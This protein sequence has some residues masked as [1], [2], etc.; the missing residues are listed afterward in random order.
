MQPIFRHLALIMFFSLLLTTAVSAAI[1][2]KDSQVIFDVDYNQFSSDSQKQITSNGQLNILN[3]GTEVAN[4]TLSFSNLPA[5]YNAD[6]VT[7][8]S[9]AAGET[10]TIA[11]TIKVPHKKESGESTIGTIIVQDTATKATLASQ[12]LIQNTKSMLSLYEVEIVYTDKNGKIQTEQFTTENEK[13]NEFQLD[14]AVKPGTEVKMTF[15]IENLFDRDY[16]Q[17]YAEL[18]NIEL[19]IEPDDTR[20]FVDRKFEELYTFENLDAKKKDEKVIT[21]TVDEDVDPNE[22]IFEITLTGEDGKNVN[23]EVKKEFRLSTER[24]RDD[25][26]IV[27]AEITPEILTCEEETNLQISIKNLGTNDQE[28]AGLAIYNQKLG[29]NENIQNIYL[30]RAS[31]EDKNTY[32]YSKIITIPKTASEGSYSLDVTVFVKK[33]EQIDEKTIPLKIEACAVNNPQPPE[34]KDAPE[35]S[36]PKSSSSPSEN[37]TVE[38]PEATEKPAKDSTTNTSTIVKSTEDPYTSDD[39]IAGILLVGIIIILVFITWCL[40]LLFK[41]E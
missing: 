38:K 35:T 33:N 4:I 1:E 7:G 6:D 26:R 28:Y 39:I 20:L 29:L 3:T 10:K 24:T 12:P 27:A 8:I 41:K 31:K 32:Q 25:V 22:F 9:L 37:T 16:D 5:G 21:F 30:S 2:I 15:S 23:H 13:N 40:V 11:Y 14:E 36:T 19:N 34:N 18:D 17:D